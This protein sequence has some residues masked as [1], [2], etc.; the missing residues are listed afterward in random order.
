LLARLMA[1]TRSLKS[2]PKRSTKKRAVSSVGGEEVNRSPV[3]CVKVTAASGWPFL[4]LRSGPVGRHP[5]VV[6]AATMQV[7]I[8]SPA[9]PSSAPATMPTSP[10]V[11]RRLESSFTVGGWTPSLV[12]VFV[13]SGAAVAL[14]SEEDTYS[15]SI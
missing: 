11:I 2:T 5:F 6:E 14:A 1:W 13:C 3:N 8:S 15:E 12:P 4:R 7:V 9:T 10:P